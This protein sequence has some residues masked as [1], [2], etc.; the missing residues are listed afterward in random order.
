VKGATARNTKPKNMDDTL[1]AKVRIAIAASKSD[2]AA[3][4]RLLTMAAKDG[5]LKADLLSLGSRQSIANYYRSERP[6]TQYVSA[7]PSIEKDRR[8]AGSPVAPRVLAAVALVY[9]VFDLPLPISRV[10]LRD[11]T[12]AHLS[13]AKDYYLEYGAS[14][15]KKGE[16]YRRLQE[17]LVR[18]NK[19]TV[20]EAFTVKQVN[21]ILGDA[22]TEDDREERVA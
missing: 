8:A 4:A 5:K 9:T 7:L 3:A 12:A 22:I 18:S 21:D 10:K 14:F 11:A 15:A 6:R 19:H 13:D 20:G 17:R 16:A 1:L 2:V